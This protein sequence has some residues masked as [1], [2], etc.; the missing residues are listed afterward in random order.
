MKHEF[1]T[2]DTEQAHNFEISEANLDEL[3][4]IVMTNYKIFQGM[5]EQEPYSIDHYQEKLKDIAPKILIAK[6]D[7]KIVGDSISFDRKDSLYIWIMGVLKE[8]RNKG[9]ANKLF[10]NNEQFARANEYK[11]V[12]VKVYNVSKEMLRVLL[13]RGYQITEVEQ[14]ET[15]PKYNAVHLELKI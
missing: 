1:P 9:I 15:D 10:E 8:H 4:Q 7:G 11:S 12:T 14:S 6:V 5:Y 2:A 3:E 13:A